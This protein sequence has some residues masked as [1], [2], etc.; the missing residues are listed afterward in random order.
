MDF[1]EIFENCKTIAVYGMSRD[2]VKAAYSVPRFMQSE[3]YKVI[4]INPNADEIAELKAYDTLME[5]EEEIDILNVFRPSEEAA[6]VLQEAIKRHK[7]RGDIKIIWIQEGIH[8]ENGKELA[9][10]NGMEY[11]EDS[12]IYKVYVNLNIHE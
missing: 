11:I 3:G 8:V 10:E 6:Q 7:E 12:C 1:V 4:P 2:T 5:V 9:E